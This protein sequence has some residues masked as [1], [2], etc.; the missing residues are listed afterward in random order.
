MFLKENPVGAQVIVLGAGSD[1]RYFALKAGF[2]P[3]S[4]LLLFLFLW[5][6]TFMPGMEI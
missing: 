1:T 5:V 4:F 3:P 6:H 2:L